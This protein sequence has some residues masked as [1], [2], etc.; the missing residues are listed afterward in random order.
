LGEVKITQDEAIKLYN[1]F[2]ASM[3]DK[4]KIQRFDPEKG[5]FSVMKQSKMVSEGTGWPSP[6]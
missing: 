6:A 5:T 2:M 3:Q 4:V 1:R